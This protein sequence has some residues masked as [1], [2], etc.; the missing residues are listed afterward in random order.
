M[1]KYMQNQLKTQRP[2]F[3]ASSRGFANPLIVPYGVQ[4]GS[5]RVGTFLRA[6]MAAGAPGAALTCSSFKEVVH[7]TAM[8]A[9][10]LSPVRFQ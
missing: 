8:T 10:D 5:C 6:G 2:F 9:F 4:C 7:G 3:F 1:H